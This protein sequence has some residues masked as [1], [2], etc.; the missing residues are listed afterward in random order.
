[1]A[2]T[3]TVAAV[4]EA[5]TGRLH[6]YVDRLTVNGGSLADLGDADAV[7]ARMVASLPEPTPWNDRIGPFL[8]TSRVAARF[9]V[10]RQAI[11]E[12]RR[13][14]TLLACR[15]RDGV[16]VYPAWQFDDGRVRPEVA[17][18][19]RLLRDPGVDGWTLA[20]WSVTAMGPLGDATPVEYAATHGVDDALEALV[21]E[22][23]AR[24]RA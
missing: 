18:L 16:W 3:D 17:A 2:K 19:L 23:V 20:A 1:M 8:R 4:T 12:R 22:Q 24:W 5:L 10:S 6:A 14:G 11:D 13:R 15:T 21:A 9:G 7:A